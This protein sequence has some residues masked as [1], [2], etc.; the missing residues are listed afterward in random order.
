MPHFFKSLRRRKLEREGLASS[1]IRPK[2]SETI[3]YYIN[4]SKIVTGIIFALLW[5]FFALVLVLPSID[6]KSKFYLVL[7]QQA[8]KTIYSDFNFSYL[9]ALATN[10]QKELASSSVPLI[11]QIDDTVSE[12]NIEEIYKVFKNF[13]DSSDEV[14][15]KPIKETFDIS[16]DTIPILEQF[17]NDRK[18]LELFR[19]KLSGIIY[20]GIISNDDLANIQDPNTTEICIINKNKLLR[21]PIPAV[22][23][24]TPKDAAKQL[25]NLVSVDYVHQS[26]DLLKKAIFNIT[27]KLF[28]P[29]LV[30]D[31]SLT[32]VEIQFISSSE[33]NDVYQE[34]KKGDTIIRKGEKIDASILEKFEAYETER[35]KRNIYANFLENF[36]YNLA[37]SFIL[38]IIT[39]V[40]FYSIHKKTIFDNQKMGTTVFVLISSLISVYFSLK[41]FNLLSSE[42]N[43]PSSLSTCIIPLALPS[44]L[45]TLFIGI[46]GAVFASVI[47]SIIAAIKV[48]NY[49]AIIV[50]IA[51]GCF[52]SLAVINSRNYKHLFI[53]SVTAILLTLIP[54]ELLCFFQPII[55]NTNTFLPIIALCIINAI[56]TGILALA[57]LFL[58]ESL[59]QVSTDM[60][61]I[62]LCDYNHPLL[63]RLQ[64][65]APGTYHHSLMVA[66]LAERAAI[67]VDL[68]PVKARACALFHDIGKLLRP[69]YF[70][71]NNASTETL[72]SNIKPGI[73]S[74][75][76]LNHVKDGIT[77]A[78]K[79]KLGGLI[80]DAIEQHHGDDLVYY[81]YQK[82]LEENAKN[83]GTKVTESEFR[84]PGPKP[85]DK[86]ITIVSLAD[87]CEAASRSIEKPTASKIETLVWEIIR[88][89]IREGQLDNSE[90]G[91]GELAKARIS[92]TKT[93][94]SMLHARIS[95]QI[96]DKKR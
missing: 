82:A 33:K 53:R 63:K 76:I 41:F 30:Y 22:L 88:R 65:E 39:I 95:Y 31:K 68:N 9:D 59:F 96:S 81:F 54:S 85:I 72:H 84:Y 86:E 6:G 79:Y 71:E 56:S 4:S 34:V 27:I 26:R 36:S 19:S 61:L 83:G 66:T 12:N 92:F 46:R 73:S 44:I 5:F 93:L 62:A 60:N 55:N 35:A 8:P 89:K 50:G 13:P 52:T 87:S 67:D 17:E 51:L 3:S 15:L 58:V 77:L 57:V 43:I 48:D 91:L 2:S 14:N 11:Y 90:L 49:Y 21:N 20:K 25:S 64:V 7:D 29:N 42:F 18:R 23:L 24:S 80:I 32:D 78:I 74:M 16:D 70:T 28:K 75:I 10:K 37:I 45:L 94:T 47:V 38:L 40:Y 1:K 69:E